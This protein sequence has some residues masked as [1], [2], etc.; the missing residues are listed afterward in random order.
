MKLD[1]GCGSRKV[2][3]EY[4]GLD[5]SKSP[6]VNIIASAEALPFKNGSFVEIYTR[7]CVQHIKDDEKVLSEM[8]RI[9]QENGKVELTLAS[10]RGWVFYQLRWMLKK[11]PYDLFHIYT[12][13]KIKQM[14]KKQ[15]F[16]SINIV[17][18]KSVHRFGYDIVAEAK[19]ENQRVHD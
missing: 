12:F 17:K 2:G 9:L 13:R 18:I 11:K 14:L 10:W 16:R 4:I 7:R 8:F 3:S 1:I 19:R 5:I 6:N 15:G